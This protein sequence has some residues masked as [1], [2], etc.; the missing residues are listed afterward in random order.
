MQESLFAR[1]NNIRKNSFLDSQFL[2]TKKKYAFVGVGM[3]SLSNLYPLLRYFGINLKY[4]C[5]R[6]SSR[7]KQMSAHFP[8]CQFIHSVEDLAND[9][10]VEGIFVSAAAEAHFGILTTLLAAQKKV[11]VEKPPCR[12]LPELMQLIGASESGT[13]R[14]GLQRRHWPGNKMAFKNTHTANTY[15]YQFHFGDYIQ[16]DPFSELFIHALDYVNH[17]FGNFTM[18]SFTNKK[19]GKGITTQMHV[20]HSNQVFGL[21]QLSTHFSWNDPMDHLSVNCEHELI[22]I[23]YPLTINGIQKPKRFLNIP[24]ERLLQQPITTREYFSTGHLIVPVMELNTLVL[25]GFYDEIKSFIELVETGTSPQPKNDLPGLRNIYEIM[26]ILKAK[27]S[28]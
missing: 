2:N 25:Q 19:D 27:K 28:G 24:A 18:N 15:V 21:I 11:F 8:G 22:N 13:C 10:E 14:V 26:E 9:A 7:L 12:D 1:L 16:G 5:T 6:K 3:H 23:T 17:L 20:T 4:I